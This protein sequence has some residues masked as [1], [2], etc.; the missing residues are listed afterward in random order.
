MRPSARGEH[1]RPDAVEHWTEREVDETA[2]KDVRLGRRFGELLKQFGDGMGESI[3]F[4]CQDWANTK[5]AYR[6]FAN[7][8]VEEG[9]ILSGHFAATRAR[10]DAIDGPILLIQDT[11]EFSY[12]RANVSAVG[13]TKSINS[14][15][16]KRG[17]LRHHT[18]CG[19]LM[20][21]S[22]AVTTQGLPLGLA[23]VKFWTRKKFRGT[24]ALKRKVNPT[25]VPIEKKESVRWLEN[26]RQSIERLGQPERCIHVGDRESDIYELYCL[27]QD[28]GAHFLVRACVD[29]LA[30]DGGHTIATEMEE[31]SVK[32]LHHVEVLNDK[33][34]ITKVT[35]EIKFR[36]ITVQPPIGKQ[37][38]YP[39]LELAVIH[40]SERGAPKGRKPIE[41]K[42]ITDLPVRGRAEAIEKINW[43]AMR[44][45]IEVFHKILKSGCRAEDS[46]LRTAERL[47]NLMAVFC[48]LSWRVLWLTM[49]NRIAPDASPTFALTESET[50]LL[51]QLVGDSGNRR[52]KPGTLSFYLTKL[53]RLGA[54]LARTG[55]PPPGNAVI[56][57]GL[58]RLTDVEIGA[59]LRVLAFVGN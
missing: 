41:W 23:A 6:F 16:D 52:C 3:P 12:Q 1:R 14:G 57:R 18:V 26:L 46:K 29:R 27:T 56:W 51:D 58:S 33:G 10:Y 50:A 21:S 38:R 15:R 2:F 30:G 20:H 28:I 44:W 37:K 39:S 59:E 22:L 45:K 40:A 11:T 43:Y 48:I 31:T 13:V 4:A 35:L 7:E 25:R 34:E 8:R 32:G 49:L 42:L 55:D 24:A 9:D 5:A 54:Y 53:A 17:R 19:M 47:A 36:R